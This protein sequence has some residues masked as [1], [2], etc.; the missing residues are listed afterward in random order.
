MT[1]GAFLVFKYRHVWRKRS[2]W[3]SRVDVGSKWGRE[4]RTR[5]RTTGKGFGGL[6]CSKVRISVNNNGSVCESVHHH[7]HPHL[8]RRIRSWLRGEVWT[9]GGWRGSSLLV[10]APTGLLV[11]FWRLS[12]LRMKLAL[13]NVTSAGRAERRQDPPDPE[14][15][16]I[17]LRGGATEEPTHLFWLQKLGTIRDAETFRD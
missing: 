15:N 4:P 1:F 2:V 11:Q 16:R 13:T 14:I 5:T 7:P 17:H 8:H 9:S 12:E 6:F 3:S 10:W